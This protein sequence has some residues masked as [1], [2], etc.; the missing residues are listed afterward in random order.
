M[1]GLDAGG[2]SSGRWLAS[3]YTGPAARRMLY[4][5]YLPPCT[6]AG[7]LPLLVMLHG[8]DQGAN[9]FAQGT[10]MNVLAA[11]RGFAVVYP[12]QSV[13]SHPQACWKW[14]ERA[15]QRGGGDAA[16]IAGIVNKV[17][18]DHPVD[19]ARIYICGFSAGGALAH[20][21]A[22]NYPGLIAAVGVHSG[23]LFGA[24]R[25]AVDAVRV[26]RRGDARRVES[27]IGDVLERQPAFP[28][29][30]TIL[31]QGEQDTVVR[32]INHEQLA[33]QALRLN[34]VPDGTPAEITLHERSAE[35]HAWQVRDVHLGGRHLLRAVQIS[36]LK[37]AWS[38]GDA[39]L[40]F[41]SA[42]G[43][44]ASAM[45]ADFFLQHRREIAP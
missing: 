21:V 12:Q 5:L 24:A 32:K 39:R 22:L 19:R 1:N 40:V 4:W 31:L 42:P 14:Y 3:M 11:Q 29:L 43:P 35:A 44:D 9:T 30:P 13:A 26:M 34:R 23:P 45:L 15:T 27:A 8:C 18:A 2:S 36:E 33:R 41:N 20:I 38:G 10:R 16:M 17:G 7:G 6:P 37:H 28:S 25:N